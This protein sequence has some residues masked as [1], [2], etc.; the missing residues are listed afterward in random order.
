MCPQIPLKIPERE[1]ASQR[2][3]RFE[4][5]WCNRQDSPLPR[6]YVELFKNVESLTNVYLILHDSLYYVAG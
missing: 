4:N 1:M 5:L 2:I 6:N 3:S